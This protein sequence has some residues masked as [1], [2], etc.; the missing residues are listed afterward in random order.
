MMAESYQRQAINSFINQLPASAPIRMIVQSDAVQAALA[1]FDAAD[2]RALESQTRYQAWHLRDLRATTFGILVGALLL[3][4]LD[5]WVA[6]RPRTIIGGFQ[7][8]ALVVTFGSLLLINRMRPLDAWMSFRADAERLRNK[9]FATI[10]S[11]ATPPGSDPKDLISQKLDL[12]SAKRV[13][14]DSI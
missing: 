1:A 2:A 4:P 7:T 12:P 9:I 6:G 3:F 10:L 8:A 14:L 11:S 5:Q 13:S